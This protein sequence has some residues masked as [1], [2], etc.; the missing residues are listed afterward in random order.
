MMVLPDDQQQPPTA[1]ATAAVAPTVLHVLCLSAAGERLAKPF[2]SQSVHHGVLEFLA[3]AR[4]LLQQQ[5]QQQQ[6]HGGAA[7]GC[8]KSYVCDQNES[9]DGVGRCRGASPNLDGGGG[10]ATTLSLIIG[11]ATTLFCGPDGSTL[12]RSSPAGA[13]AGAGSPASVA[14][15]RC[16]DA[17]ALTEL[18]RAKGPVVVRGLSAAQGRAIGERVVGVELARVLCVAPDLDGLLLASDDGAHKEARH[19]MTHCAHGSDAGFHVLVYAWGRELGGKSK[20]KLGD[21][22]VQSA[23]LPTLGCTGPRHTG[24]RAVAYHHHGDHG[25]RGGGGAGG[26]D[27]GEPVWLSLLQVYDSARRDEHGLAGVLRCCA[28]VQE[29]GGSVLARTLRRY[30]V[31]R[32]PRAGLTP[33]RPELGMVMANLAHVQSGGL[34]LDPFC[35]CGSLLLSAAHLGAVTLGADVCHPSPTRPATAVA[36]NFEAV[37]LGASPVDVWTGDVFWAGLRGGTVDAILTDPPCECTCGST[38]TCHMPV[39]S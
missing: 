26:G 31:S 25:R 23:L 34:V 19:G 8:S 22:L 10:S 37:G 2:G 28:L 36:A 30:H 35:G 11:T 20:R 7:S 4:L 5:Q 24:V 12:I 33:I 32:R 29:C 6:R 27:G 17:A 16:G 13:G 39:T 1:A 3:L 14:D 15:S 9:G 21:A 38:H 18:L